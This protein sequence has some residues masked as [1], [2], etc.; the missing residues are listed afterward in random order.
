MRFS[1]PRLVAVSVLLVASSLAACSSEAVPGEDMCPGE[2]ADALKVCAEGT[3]LKGI[4]VSY[5]QGNVDWKAVKSSGHPF[6]F[7]R[8][9]DGTKYPDNKFDQ[10]WKATKAAGVLRGVYQFF[11]PAQDVDAQVNLFL[12]KLKEAGGMEPGDLP[13]VLDLETA[14]GVSSETI[15]E[16]ALKWLAKMEE[17][18]GV[19][20]IV[21]TSARMSSIIGNTFSKWPLWV[22]N[23][24][25][26]CPTMPSGWATWDFWQN[27]DKGKV[28]GVSGSCDTN[29]FQGDMA[30]LML[31]TASTKS[32]PEMP[33]PPPDQEGGAQMGDG[34]RISGGAK[35][36]GDAPGY[37]SACR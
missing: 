17:A 14:D 24:E 29:Q 20:P 10:N 1:R 26:S 18:T 34:I 9:S 15:R 16:K 19:R 2:S 35:S 23:Y 32:I 27:S 36:A 22:A 13:T 12:S 4:D 21:Y 11:R 7:V 28:P 30:K 5:Y 6:A 33:A 25:T 37:S 31:L 3:I 8:V